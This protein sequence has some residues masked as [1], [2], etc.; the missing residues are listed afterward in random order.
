[1][2]AWSLLPPAA[3]GV[4]LDQPS[5]ERDFGE[6]LWAVE[7][8][9]CWKLERMQEYSEVGFPSW[10]AFMAGEWSLALRL[11]EEERPAIAAFH[12]KL[13]RR[14]SRFYRVRV[15]AEPVTPYLQWELHCLRV[16]A[17]CGEGIRVVHAS[18]I[19]AFEPSGPL[20]ELVLLRGRVLYQTLYDDRGEPNGAVRCAD[21]VVVSSYGAFTRGLYEAGED[22]ESYFARAIAHLPPPPRQAGS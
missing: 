9:D 2:P 11:Y 21:P 15:L 17:S 13:R 18:A 6:N 22:V 19:S 4:R 14:G 1:M 20:P 10:E 3:D 16:R 8:A 7:G 12:E 5:Y